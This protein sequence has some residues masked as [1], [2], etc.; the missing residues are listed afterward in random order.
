MGKQ[1]KIFDNCNDNLSLLLMSY[2]VWFELGGPGSFIEVVPRDEL[3]VRMV[4]VVVRCQY[5]LL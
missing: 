5:L 1:G 4:Y 2:H 3:M